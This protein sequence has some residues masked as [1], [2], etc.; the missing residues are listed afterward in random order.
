MTCC[1]ITCNNAITVLRAKDKLFVMTL[2]AVASG[3]VPLRYPDYISAACASTCNT[4]SQGREVDAPCSILY[5]TVTWM[6]ATR[7]T[8]PGPVC[9]MQTLASVDKDKPQPSLTWQSSGLYKSLIWHSC[10]TLN[11][12][13]LL[14]WQLFP[15]C[16]DR[17]LFMLCGIIRGMHM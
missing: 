9:T 3:R 4:G 11:G 17:K 6:S 12:V 5:V 10:L 8:R 15:Q 14:T 13:F 16:C 2:S 1:M 7:I